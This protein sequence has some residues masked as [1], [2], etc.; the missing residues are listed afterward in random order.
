MELT[1]DC[2]NGVCGDCGICDFD[3]LEPRVFSEPGTLKSLPSKVPLHF[4]SLR[5]TFEKTGPA[6]FFGHLEMVQIFL[7]ALRM[8]EVSLKFSTGFNPKPEV[9]FGDTLPLGMSSL[10]ESIILNAG[11]EVS[12]FGFAESVNPFLPAGL[13]ITGCREARAGEKEASTLFY[14]V[15]SQTPFDGEKL[16]AFEDAE[17][18]MMEKTGK[19]GKRIVLDIKNFVEKLS[20]LDE[21]TLF[22]SL[23][24]WEERTLRPAQILMAVLGLEAENVRNLDILKVPA[25]DGP[26]REGFCG[27]S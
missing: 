17:A 13:R 18:W 26:G 21:K 14:E 19:R 25:T 3:T 8:A 9:R 11:A 4:R 23:V 20:F 12:T 24:S 6:R 7:K 1:P 5:V 27:K 2:R 15:R 16:A 10:C 22:L